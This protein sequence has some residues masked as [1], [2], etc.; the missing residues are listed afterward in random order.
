MRTFL[1]LF[2][3]ATLGLSGFAAWF[4]FGGP[5]DDPARKRHNALVAKIANVQSR[6][7]TGDLTAQFEVGKLYRSASPE[8]RDFALAFEW[9]TKAAGKGHVGAQ[10]NLGGM[11]ASGEYVRQ[12]Y[13]RAVEWYR[14]AANLGHHLGA[15]F[16]LGDLYFR[17][18]GVPN[19]YAEA[20]GWYTK[21]AT[22][23]HSVAQYRLG[24]MYSEGWVEGFDAIRAYKWFTLALRGQDRITAFDATLDARAGLSHVAAKMNENQIKRAEEA[25]ANWLAKR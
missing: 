16:S 11:Y 7:E 2:M 25:V 15:Q 13:F 20:L 24:V 17:G 10:Y 5:E 14:L 23:G 12:D 1:F 3:V 9:F 21:A 22:Q 8:T 4:F 19:N 18:Q 6:A